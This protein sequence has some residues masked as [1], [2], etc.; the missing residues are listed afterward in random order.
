MTTEFFWFGSLL[1]GIPSC[2][3]GGF[4]GWLP[5]PMAIVYFLIFAPWIVGACGHLYC[6]RQRKLLKASPK[7]ALHRI[8]LIGNSKSFQAATNA[9]IALIVIVVAIFAIWNPM[10]SV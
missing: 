5:V 7:A 4:I 10:D 8:D 1:V 3:A 2:I 9:A 6:V